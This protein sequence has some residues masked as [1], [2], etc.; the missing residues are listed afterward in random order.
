MAVSHSKSNT[1]GDFTGTVTVFNSQGSTVTAAATDLLRATDWNSA[2]N[3]FIT[4]AGN[5]AGN[6][7]NATA[8]NI[9]WAGAG[10]VTLNMS[11]AAGGGA[12]ISV[13][14]VAG[15]TNSYYDPQGGILTGTA[16]SSHPPATTYVQPMN[17]MEPIAFQKANVVKSI[18]VGVPAGSS[19]NTQQTFLFNYKHEV[20]IYRR[21]DYGANSLS[22]SHLLSGSMGIT[23]SFVH[24]STSMVASM[25]YVTNSNGGTTSQ[26]TTSNATANLVAFFNGPR[27]VQIPFQAT[28]LTDG[29]YFIFQGHSSTNASTAG[30]AS[31]LYNVSNLH[32]APQLFGA[33]GLQFLGSTNATSAHIGPQWPEFHGAANAIT[34]NAAMNYTAISNGTQNDWYINFA[35]F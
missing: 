7:A 16:Y 11:T 9:V 29:E 33:S 30:T 31:V 19:S 15:Y 28:T 20:R 3:E 6:S 21:S 8:T 5:T 25:L 4:I 27:L 14:D 35:N 18:S 32:I 34:T 17:L 22:L 13:S 2:H 12:T 10:G 23:F 26:S 1:I 24:T